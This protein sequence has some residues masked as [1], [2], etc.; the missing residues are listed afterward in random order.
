VVASG[1]THIILA[2][3]RKRQE[4]FKFKTSLEIMYFARKDGTGDLNVK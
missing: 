2:L 3:G 4:N 1:N